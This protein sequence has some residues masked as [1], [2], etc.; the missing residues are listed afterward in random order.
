MGDNKNLNKSKV[1][2]SNN[3]RLVQCNCGFRPLI[4]NYN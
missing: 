1:K 4:L 3:I 2:S